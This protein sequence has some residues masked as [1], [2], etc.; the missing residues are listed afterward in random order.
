MLKI[1]FIALMS[2]S[3]FCSNADEVLENKNTIVV[4][5]KSEKI[6]ENKTLNFFKKNFIYGIFY[7]SV[8]DEKYQNTSNGGGF[9]IAYKL[10]KP[11][12]S[13]EVLIDYDY[14]YSEYSVSNSDLSR[15][16]IN[17]FN[18]ITLKPTFIMKEYAKSLFWFP[19]SKLYG[20]FG[21]S[22]AE[23]D[24]H[25]IGAANGN[26]DIALAYGVGFDIYLTD[27]LF[28]T[29][30]TTMLRFHT[31]N[32]DINITSCGFRIEL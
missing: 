17:H 30:D 23:I 26:L 9:S 10:I 24:K 5:E 28:L 7:A 12:P 31:I 8:N 21:F 6:E 19:K 29:L 4:A 18:T 14:R 11:I 25:R 13:F 1:V 15:L 22:L 32:Q 16:T 27:W 2:L 20:K 3:T